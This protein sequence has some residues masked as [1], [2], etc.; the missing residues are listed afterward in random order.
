VPRETTGGNGIA[1]SAPLKCR[2]GQELSRETAGYW[3]SSAAGFNVEK[4]GV[5]ERG[6]HGLGR[7]WA[8]AAAA[9]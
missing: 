5:Q 1:S 6:L 2:W 4:V 9:L 8:Q 7:P 3:W